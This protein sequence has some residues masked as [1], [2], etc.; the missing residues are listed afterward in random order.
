MGV[1]LIFPFTPLGDLFGFKPL[2]VSFLIAMAAI[3]A[4]YII[5]GD[6]VK[7]IFYRRVRF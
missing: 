1:T 5:S 7:G 4:L 2:P 6:V 3:V